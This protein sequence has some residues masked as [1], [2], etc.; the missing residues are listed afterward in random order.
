MIK[1]IIISGGSNSGRTTIIEKT[2]RLYEIQGIKV[3]II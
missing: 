1:K 2:K 3:I